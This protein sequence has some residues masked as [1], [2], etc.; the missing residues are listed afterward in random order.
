MMRVAVSVLSYVKQTGNTRTDPIPRNKDGALLISLVVTMTIIAL[1]GGAMLSLMS[2]STYMSLETDNAARALY[3]AEAGLAYACLKC[4]TNQTAR[5]YT[6]SDNAGEFEITVNSTPCTY[7]SVGYVNRNT[8]F[9][10]RVVLTA[11]CCNCITNDDVVYE[12]DEGSGPIVHGPHGPGILS[13]PNEMWVED[14]ENT[15]S[16]EGSALQFESA[17]ST[18]RQ[19]MELED[20]DS[21]D[22]TTNGTLSAWI[23][24]K[25]YNS[26]AGIIHKGKSN[27]RESYT[28]QMYSGGKKVLMGLNNGASGAYVLSKMRLN[29]NTWYFVAGTWGADGLRVYINGVEDNYKSKANLSAKITD[30]PVYIG[31][32]YPTGA[33]RH[34]FDGIIDR[35]GIFDRTLDEVKLQEYYLGLTA[36]WSFDSGSSNI[37]YDTATNYH[38]AYN[39]TVYGAQLTNEAVSEYAFSFDSANENYIQGSAQIAT[40]YPFVLAAWVHPNPIGTKDYVPLSLCRTDSSK[41]AYGLMIGEDENGRAGMRARNT[42]PRTIYNSNAID[43]RKWHFQ[44]GYFMD[45]RA[46]YLFVDGEQAASSTS[47]SSYNNGLNVWAIG[48]WCDR[49]PKSYF[50]GIID[51]VSVFD[52]LLQ[53]EVWD[54][55]LNT[56]Y[57]KEKP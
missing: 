21:L 42:S 50:D 23:Y 39:G 32:Q 36:K 12:C 45:A 40:N 11:P 55:V 3:M 31:A 47:S 28:L 48:R 44:V 6:L 19:Y 27:S 25:K 16:G 30:D 14:P 29:L 9:E 20:V 1:L 2:T 34:F 24:I 54:G 52:Q 33:N 10:A 41:V 26:A 5:T 8:P 49:T 35:V 7:T 15:P 51:Q 37:V 17:T 38:D 57:E 13:Q 4:L 18:N 43:D 53:P 22:L 56:I 46:R